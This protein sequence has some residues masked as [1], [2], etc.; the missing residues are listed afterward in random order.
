MMLNISIVK[1]IVRSMMMIHIS[2]MKITVRS[3]TM[4]IETRS[5]K[6]IHTFSIIKYIVMAM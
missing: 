5:M 2:F 4:I 6:V 1:F 3:M